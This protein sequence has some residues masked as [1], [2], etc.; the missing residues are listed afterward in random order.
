MNEPPDAHT[1]P[2]LLAL[3]YFCVEV[4]CGCGGRRRGAGRAFTRRV[5]Q[6]KA[7]LMKNIFGGAE[8]FCPAVWERNVAS[9]W[10]W[11]LWLHVFSFAILVLLVTSRS[12][13]PKF[14]YTFAGCSSAFVS[15]TPP[16]LTNIL[17]LYA[18]G[19][20]Q[21]RSQEPQLFFMHQQHVP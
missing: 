3:Q 13:N 18:A 2:L 1:N 7:Q 12:W 16:R 6:L 17:N 9:G 15:A 20:V 5:A 19:L 8:T 14:T 4:L 21:Q 11:S 10:F